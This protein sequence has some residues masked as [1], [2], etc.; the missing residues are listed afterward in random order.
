MDDTLI[1]DI[2]LHNGTDSSYY[3]SKGYHV[4]AVEANP[5]LARQ[6]MDRLAA[7][8]REGRLTILNVGISDAEGTATFWVNELNSEQSSFIQEVGCRD[9]SP[10]HSIEVP[11]TRLRPILTEFGVP[12]YMKIDIER[13]D[14]LCLEASI[15]PTCRCTYRS[16]HTNSHTWSACASS[17]MT[18]LRS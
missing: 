18:S 4:V 12:F 10:C 1:F 6:S 5:Q 8:V 9:G 3:L 11:T 14:Y 13:H 16:R 7:E 15:R 2:G 17:A